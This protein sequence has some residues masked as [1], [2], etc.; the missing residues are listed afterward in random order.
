MSDSTSGRGILSD[1]FDEDE[2]EWDD[3]DDA[4]EDD[5]DEMDRTEED[6]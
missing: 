4:N 6:S 1:E 3:D 2:I 5:D